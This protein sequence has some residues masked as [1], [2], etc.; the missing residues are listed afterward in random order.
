MQHVDIFVLLNLRSQYYCTYNI[1]Y[2]SY[3]IG[4]MVVGSKCNKL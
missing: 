4:D 3:R 2:Y 1:V